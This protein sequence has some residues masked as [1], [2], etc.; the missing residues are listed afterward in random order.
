[1]NHWRNVTV[2]ICFLLIACSPVAESEFE[3]TITRVNEYLSGKPVLLTSNRIV[4][5]NEETYIY[6]CLRIENYNLDYSVKQG[7]SKITPYNGFIYLSFNVFDN[8][9]SGDVVS[10][11][12]PLAFSAEIVPKK[13]VGF[14][15][16]TVAMSNQDFSK[17]GRSAS[18]TIKYSYQGNQWLYSDIS[19]SGGALTEAL[20]DDLKNFPQNKKFRVAIGMPD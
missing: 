19:V 16:T 10:D 3:Q 8:A 15:T 1:M 7:F 6:Y 12:S 4:K 2:L 18:I 5:G 14:S 11:I 9:N 17:S 13:A 20:A